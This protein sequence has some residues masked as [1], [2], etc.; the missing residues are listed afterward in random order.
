MLSVSKGRSAVILKLFYV[1]LII[2][3]KKLMHLKGVNTRASSS[4]LVYDTFYG[5]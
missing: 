3:K 1:N 4:C 2:I 5:L